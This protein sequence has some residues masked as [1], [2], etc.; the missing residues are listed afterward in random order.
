MLSFDVLGE[1]RG[2][3]LLATLRLRRR[4]KRG[5][6]TAFEL[7]RLASSPSRF[8]LGVPR[9]PKA[10]LPFFIAA[11]NPPKDAL[12]LSPPLLDNVPSDTADKRLGC[13]SPLEASS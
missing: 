3:T 5:R 11:R 6:L 12:S 1:W 8:I 4:E 10:D 13:S 2:C 9:P 7:V